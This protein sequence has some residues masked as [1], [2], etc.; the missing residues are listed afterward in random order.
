MRL[1]NPF[2]VW[3]GVGASLGVWRVARHA[4]MRQASRF[5]NGA[6]LVLLGCLLG[7][8]LAFCLY[9]YP[10]YRAHAAQVF[11]FWQGGLN[12][13]GA[14]LGGLGVVAILSLVWRM[15]VW[16]VF[17]HIMPLLPPLAVTVWVGCWQIGIGYGK[18]AP[19]GAW[20]ALPSPDES[21]A[22]LPRFPLQLIAALLLLLY[23]LLLELPRAAWLN[24]LN[25][26]LH[27]MGLAVNLLVFSFLRCDAAPRWAGMRSDSWAALVL[28]L[29]SVALVGIQ[30]WAYKRRR[31]KQT[32]A[33][34]L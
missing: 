22:V 26:G 30:L 14:V 1:M 31:E 12:W 15:P 18:L 34:I 6:L 20:W 5:L 33:T 9:H 7:A 16:T 2:A 25:S 19:A 11:Q 28:A 29:L 13:E 8:R 10:Y 21:G 32:G 3:V 17:E 27:W 24:A 23:F 4:P